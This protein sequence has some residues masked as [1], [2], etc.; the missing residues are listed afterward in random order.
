MLSLRD[1]YLPAAIT[2]AEKP[3]QREKNDELY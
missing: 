3:N 1:V 2:G